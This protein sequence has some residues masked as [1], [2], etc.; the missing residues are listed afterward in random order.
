MSHPI[1]TCVLAGRWGISAAALSLHTGS[2]LT[3]CTAGGDMI[4]KARNWLLGHCEI[5]GT[6]NWA[7]SSQHRAKSNVCRASQQ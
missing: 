1:T 3:G 6:G 5:K 4:I 7:E 2:S